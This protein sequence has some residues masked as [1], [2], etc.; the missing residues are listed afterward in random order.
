[1][2]LIY[3][4]DLLGTFFFAVSGVLTAA[5]H[6]MDLFGASILGFVTAIGGGTLRD[7]MIG[8]TPVNWLQD[9]NY[10]I[11]ISIAIIISIV[12]KNYVL[13]LRKTLFLFDTLGISLFT[14][15]GVKKTLLVGLDPLVAILMGVISA[16]FGGVLRDVLAN[17]VPLIFRKDFYAT[18]CILGGVIYLLIDIALGKESFSMLVAIICI[19]II[20]ILAVKRHWRLPQVM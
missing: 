15:I 4:L 18:V 13:K 3:A 12:F 10:F 8:D 19:I 16:V 2:N 7:M 6:R 9:R 1:M 14:V 5:Q 20:R 11:V 17:E